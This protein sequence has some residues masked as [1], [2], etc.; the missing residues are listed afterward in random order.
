MKLKIF[1]TKEISVE[2]LVQLIV[3][4]EQ[5]SDADFVKFDQLRSIVEIPEGAAIGT[6]IYTVNVKPLPANLVG[7]HRVV[8]S[9]SKGHRGF[10]INP[11]TGYFNLY[12]YNYQIV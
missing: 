7:N 8:Y 2:L 6:Y 3:P 12:I 1:L 9:V 10:A 5:I 4:E 11:I